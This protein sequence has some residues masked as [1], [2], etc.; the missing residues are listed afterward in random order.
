MTAKPSTGTRTRT[1]PG[2]PRSGSLA[3]PPAIFAATPLPDA[4]LEAHGVPGVP[5]L[6]VERMGGRRR[7]ASQGQ[8][9]VLSSCLF[10]FPGRSKGNPEG[11]RAKVDGYLDGLE[12]SVSNIPLLYP[13]WVYRLY[14]DYSVYMPLPP[15]GT[16]ALAELV[17][18]VR[19]RLSALWDDHSANLEV[20]A[21]R[22]V[23]SGYVDGETF[24]PSVWRYLPMTDP[25]VAVFGSCDVDNP[26]SPLLMHLADRWQS[27]AEDASNLLFLVLE[28]HW[29]PQCA[30][31]VASHIAEVDSGT[32]P[33]AQ[34]WFWRRVGRTGHL[35]GRDLFARTMR[36]AHDPLLRAFFVDLDLPWLQLTL[37]PLLAETPAYM[38][39]LTSSRPAAAAELVADLSGA[40][41]EVL[42]TQIQVDDEA[43]G[44]TA[45]QRQRRRRWAKL[46]LSTPQLLRLATLLVAGKVIAQSYER[47]GD[48]Q[49]GR[50]VSKA[51]GTEDGV[52]SISDI[53]VKA[54]YGIDEWLLHCL[55]RPEE[56]EGRATVLGAST[57]E[58]GVIRQNYA[59][60]HHLPGTPPVVAWLQGV[61]RLQTTDSMAWS[62]GVYAEV[63]VRSCLLVRLLQPD[64][65]APAPKAVEEAYARVRTAYMG[66]L[67]SMLGYDNMPR[68]LASTIRDRI[69]TDLVRNEGYMRAAFRRAVTLR[70]S[71][72]AQ[73]LGGRRCSFDEKRLRFS[74][75]DAEGFEALKEVL[76]RACLMD[77]RVM[78]VAK[79]FRVDATPW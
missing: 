31:Y 20:F 40:L 72:L 58:A 25:D 34:F 8:L 11:Y 21:C 69:K 35:Q 2:R 36:M 56:N 67:L 63:L 60:L 59:T 64:P 37:V 24:M 61:V 51:F 18:L 19:R 26:V 73:W 57:P 78:H 66:R 52:A 54:A 23:R 48:A 76:V 15:D 47:G 79:H 29:S 65:K 28:E 12:R 50:I 43:D 13:G 55:M 46:V 62:R 39:I 32:C 10:I 77:M 71:A 49:I 38:R 5:D 42:R 70:P 74:C 27:T 17:G 33:I 30:V 53:V 14:L 9:K 68:D 44:G 75:S 45:T 41:D 1:G 22:Y 4:V 3:E 16:G 6:L 7:R